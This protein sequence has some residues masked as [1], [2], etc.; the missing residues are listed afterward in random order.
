MLKYEID[1]PAL[2]LD[3]DVADENIAQ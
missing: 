1:T 3:I 2:L